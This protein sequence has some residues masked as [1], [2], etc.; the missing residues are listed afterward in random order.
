MSEKKDSPAKIV[1]WLASL[2][3]TLILF[4]A[5]A[6]AS[7]VGTLLP[8]GAGPAELEGHFSPA[9]I[10]IIEAL[11]LNNLYR[12]GW[13]RALLLLLCANLLVCTID[14]LPK[15]IRLIRRREDPFDS[16]RLSK[17]GNN[18]SMLTKMSAEQAASVLQ[19]TVSQSFGPLREI[20]PSDHY[21]AVSEKGRWSRLMV[22]GV[23]ASVVLI[24]VG[25]LAGS[26]LGFKGFMNLPEGSASSEAMPIN[27]G[28]I[29]H[30]PFQVRCDKFEVSFY[31][32]GMPAEYKSDLTILENGRD[33]LK[34]SIKVNDPLE[35]D[36]IT[37]YQA[38]YG[39]TLKQAEIELT[40]RDSGKSVKLTLPYQ[41]PRPIPGTDSVAE[42]INFQEN[43]MRFGP[44]LGLAV[45]KEGQPP[46]A[47]S[48][49]L[50][51]RPDFHG[52][53]IQNYQVKVLQVD[54]ASF[55]GLQVKRDPGIWLV[56][57]GFI[58]MTVGIGLTFYSS[59]TKIWVSI[60][61]DGRGRGTV[62][63]VAG[64]TSRNAPGF[65]ERFEELEAKLKAELEPITITEEPKKGKKELK[66]T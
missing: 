55:T 4:F 1:D 61:P 49:I 34:R 37:L 46:S 6:A 27:G 41:V 28:Q 36:G 63:A 5:L 18:A 10:S 14:R 12:T 38:S 25:A 17:F 29:I 64:R 44:A 8:Q 19:N 48:W 60:E 62:V 11:G 13:F 47:G 16:Q 45:G 52:N 26:I 66:R 7:I 35:Y 24:L 58:L 39:T 57:L 22:Y 59:H 65:G 15:T 33:V 42:I 9:M 32:S 43:M 40:D 54:K 30:L 20:T 3:L 21:C 56:Y 50:V 53:R 2:T 31:E 51:D 23:H